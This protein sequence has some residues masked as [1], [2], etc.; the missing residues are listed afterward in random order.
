MFRNLDAEQGRYGYT[1]DKMAAML[2]MTRETF[3][4]K[5]KTGKFTRPEIAKMLDTFGC[6]F[7]YLFEIGGEYAAEKIKED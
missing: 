2:G 7:E 3:G 4:R 6:S 1:D 5:K